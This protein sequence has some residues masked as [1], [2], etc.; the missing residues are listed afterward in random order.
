MVPLQHPPV[1]SQADEPESLSISPMFKG[2]KKKS[3]L[4]KSSTLDKSNT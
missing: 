3:L 4:K 2:R 1:F